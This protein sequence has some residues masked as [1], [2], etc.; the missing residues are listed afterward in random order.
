M[1][2]KHQQPQIE[3]NEQFRHA[4]DILEDSDRSIFI[5]GRAGTGK[6]TLLDYFRRTTAKKVAVLAPTGVA[7]LNVKGQTIHSF[8]RFKP[9]ITPGRVKKLR[10]DNGESI[11]RKLEAIVIDEVSMVRADLLDCVDRF[12]R[13]NGPRGD[14]PFGGIQMAFIGDLYQLPPVVTSGEK[15]VFQSLYET[16]YFY[17]ARVFDSFEMEFIELEKIYRQHDT[18]FIRLLNAIRNNTIT[19]EDLELLNRRYQPDF[20]PA[21]DDFYVYLTT[22]NK[23]AEEINAR[24]LAGLKSRLYTFTG[25]IEGDFGQEYLP[26]AVELQ[27]KVGAQIMMLNNDVEG[28]WVNGSIGKITEITQNR[29]GDRVIVAELAD[30]EEVEITPF[31][32]EIFRFFVE[33]GGL[34][35]EV[36]GEFTQYPLML[37]WAVTIHK[38]QGKTFDRVIIDV[39]KGTFAHG[40]MYVALSRCTTL[41]GIVL[42]KPAL[43]KYIWT[44]YQVM[45]FLTKYQYSKADRSCSMDSKIEIIR[46]A[47]ARKTPLEIVYLKP[48]DEKSTRVV[49]PEAVGEMEYRGKTYTGMRAF[50]LMRNEERVFRVDRI[51]EIKQPRGAKSGN[52]CP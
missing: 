8:F 26:T 1:D 3:I 49:R 28:R 11:Y 7:A 42:K 37:A 51:L 13:L 35:S 39:G 52:E 40:Q 19:A 47:I 31:T 41:D 33:G 45:D 22:T 38:G 30:G 21:P 36:I 18:R 16:P 15:E 20:E 48:S 14:K 46:K 10:S 24:R 50:C 5:T 12:L 4:L 2:S 44:N 27:L 32:W 23:L 29:R 9:G 6:S 17:G 25:S 34:Q 43:K